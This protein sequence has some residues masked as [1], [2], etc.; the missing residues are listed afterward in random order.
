MIFSCNSKAH[1]CFS[2]AWGCLVECQEREGE[3]L[4]GLLKMNQLEVSL[5]QQMSRCDQTSLF[6]C[7]SLA[8][9]FSLSRAK[10]VTA[11]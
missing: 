6:F 5:W 7:L 3:V 8:F 2:S 1:L 9:I 4:V 10:A 11:V